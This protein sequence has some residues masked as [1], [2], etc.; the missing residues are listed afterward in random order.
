M[1]IIAVYQR[2]RPSSISC[3]LTIS[4]KCVVCDLLGE[5][6]DLLLGPLEPRHQ[7]GLDEL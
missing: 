2:P 4:D 7:R 1:H 6:D 5:L 3:H